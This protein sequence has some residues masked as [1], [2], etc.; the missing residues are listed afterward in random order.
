MWKD[1]RLRW[2]PAKFSNLRRIEVPPSVS[3]WIPDVTW[4][5]RLEVDFMWRIQGRVMLNSD[6][7][8]RLYAQV[9]MNIK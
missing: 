6:G 7:Y 4:H 2:D 3:I 1:D 8:L 9:L 5:E